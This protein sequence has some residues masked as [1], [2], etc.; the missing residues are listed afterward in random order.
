MR[1]SIDA[2]VSEDQGPDQ[3]LRGNII[4]SKRSSTRSAELRPLAAPPRWADPERYLANPGMAADAARWLAERRVQAVGADNV[5]WDEVDLTGPEF[6]VLPGPLLLLAHHGIY[7]IEN[8]YLEELA[9]AAAIW[10]SFI[11]APL[12]FV[13]ATGSPVRPIA[14]VTTQ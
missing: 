10:F 12:K 2:D 8:L 14:V 11:C 9:A 3:I 6:G 13:G 7:S 5:A 1:R 4:V